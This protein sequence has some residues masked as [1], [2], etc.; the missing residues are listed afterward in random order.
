MPPS[1]Y[2]AGTT[3]KLKPYTGA[4]HSLFYEA[5]SIGK[6]HINYWTLISPLGKDAY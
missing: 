5:G 4:V 3:T 6:Q 1:F 2:S